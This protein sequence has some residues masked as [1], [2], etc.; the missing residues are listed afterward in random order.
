MLNPVIKIIHS[1]IKV[2][3]VEARLFG[4]ELTNIY[5]IKKLY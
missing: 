4:T 5:R 3:V 1:V 2:A